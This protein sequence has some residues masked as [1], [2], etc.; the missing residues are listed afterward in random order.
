MTPT[1]SPLRVFI[2]ADSRQAIAANVLAHSIS[3][4]SSVPVSI[5][6]LRLEQLPIIRRGLT[7]FTFT[8]YLV[9][10]LCGYEGRA[11]FLDADMLVLGN[12]AELFDQATGAA[13]SVV[14]DQAAFE[15]PSLMLFECQACR[16]LT[17][18]WI[19]DPA[20]DPASLSWAEAVGALSPSWSHCLG[21]SAVPATTPDLVHFTQGVPV[22]NEVRGLNRELEGE[23]VAEVGRMNHS[24]SWR[25]LMGRSVHARPTLSRFM[26]RTYGVTLS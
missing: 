6:M 9:P 24:V 21:Y 25:E 17:P 16:V 26:Q 7:E 4:R 5:T 11:L 2:G 3:T 18:E 12:I 13:V 20:N 19:D 23:W 14:M 15:W 22:W 8:R 10:W 1:T